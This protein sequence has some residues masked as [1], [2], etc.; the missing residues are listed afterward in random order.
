[1]IPSV[2]CLIYHIFQDE[3]PTL[4]SGDKG[5]LNAIDDHKGIILFGKNCKHKALYIS[6]VVRVDGRKVEDQ[7]W[8]FEGGHDVSF[9]A[10]LMEV[11]DK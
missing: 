6:E 7:A 5:Y 10:Q 3:L 4:V 8:R 11:K 9:N 2:N 1:M